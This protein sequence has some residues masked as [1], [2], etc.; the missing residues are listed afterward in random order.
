MDFE[1]GVIDKIFKS[2]VDPILVGGHLPH[3]QTKM[4]IS[5]HLLFTISLFKLLKQ[6]C[7]YTQPNLDLFQVS[8]NINIQLRFGLLY[9][10]L[11]YL[12]PTWESQLCEIL[13]SWKDGHKKNFVFLPKIFLNQHFFL[14]A[15]CLN[16][17]I[18]QQHFSDSKYSWTKR[19]VD[20]DPTFFN[21]WHTIFWA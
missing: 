18:F 20:V 19:I 4:G 5:S 3:P 15:N 10:L 12:A 7:L 8:S 2:Q 9:W 11:P 21:L 13:Q 14:D 6:T 1:N 16:Q 17:N